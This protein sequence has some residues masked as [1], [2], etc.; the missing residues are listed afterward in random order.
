MCFPDHNA[1]GAEK[2]SLHGR[3]GCVR[4]E[5]G[6]LPP[7][8]VS[9]EGLVMGRGWQREVSLI[10]PGGP[11]CSRRSQEVRT[12]RFALPPGSPPGPFLIL[13]SLKGLQG[14]PPLRKGEERGKETR[15]QEQRG[16]SECRGGER[17]NSGYTRQL[18]FL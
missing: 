3:E 10:L 11:S 9:C 14:I 1:S 6:A 12:T 5:R 16:K 18:H 2:P 17:M 8:T 7:G 13:A 4:G 15:G